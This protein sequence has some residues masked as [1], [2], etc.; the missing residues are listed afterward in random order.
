MWQA[1]SVWDCMLQSMD[2]TGK[3]LKGDALANKLEAATVAVRNAYSECPS[4]GILVRAL[5]EHGTE[6]LL[7][8]VHFVPGTPIK[9]MLARPTNGVS[10]VLDKFA[11]CEFT[12]EYKYDGERCQVLLQE[13]AAF[14][15]VSQ[16]DF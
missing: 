14:S 12:C 11:N 6:Q 15:E 4:Y 3:M 16:G 8:R 13:T 5:L 9:A 7:E 10:E 2:K 1:S